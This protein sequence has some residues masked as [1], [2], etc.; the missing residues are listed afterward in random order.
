[1]KKIVILEG[2]YNEEHEVSLNTSICVQKS[3]K[4]LNLNY[5]IFKVKPSEF[6]KKIKQYDDNYLFFNALHGPYGEDGQIQ[7]ELI[8]NNLRNIEDS[9]VKKFLKN[10]KIIY[11]LFLTNMIDLTSFC[12]TSLRISVS[13][14]FL[15][16][17]FDENCNPIKINAIIAY[18]Q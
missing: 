3:L 17:L 7:N 6:K 14:V 2:G 5:E 16:V 18:I 1:M 4:K 8:N 9:K 13:V 11:P 10:L 12:F 15:L